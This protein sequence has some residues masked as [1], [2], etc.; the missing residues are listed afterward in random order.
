MWANSSNCII[1]KL[2]S[3]QNFASRI[4][5]GA[6][7]FD[8]VT[9]IL[10]ELEW[11]LVSTQLYYR[12]ATLAFK[13]MTGCT[14]DYLTSIFIKQTFIIIMTRI[15]TIFTEIDIQIKLKMLDNSNSANPQVAWARRATAIFILDNPNIIK[16]DKHFQA[17]TCVAG[18]RE[19]ERLPC[20]GLVNLTSFMS[21]SK[22]Y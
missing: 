10:K 17:V 22:F 18:V 21:P 20:S 7:K 8:H 13:C 2:Q 14:P 15:F 1:D 3:V 6:R 16:I 4:V 12:S 9:P 11:L 5:T 19:G